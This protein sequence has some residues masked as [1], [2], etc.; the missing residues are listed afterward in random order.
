MIM[1]K[2]RY[3]QEWHDKD[4]ASNAASTKVISTNQSENRR[5]CSQEG[6]ELTYGL[7]IILYMIQSEPQ[8][9]TSVIESVMILVTT[10]IRNVSGLWKRYSFFPCSHHGIWLEDTRYMTMSPR[11]RIHSRHWSTTISNG[12][13]SHMD[14]GS[15][16]EFGVGLKG[17]L[18]HLNQL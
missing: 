11:S 17:C 12:S 16:D 10:D 7:R 3:C 6:G 8:D 2:E 4:W 13:T 5:T 15:R 1:I 18:A 9:S 14:M